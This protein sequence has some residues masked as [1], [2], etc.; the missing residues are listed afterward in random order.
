MFNLTKSELSSRTV[1]YIDIVNDQ[2]NPN[3]YNKEEDPAYF[4]SQVNKRG[5][6]S[7]TWIDELKAAK[8]KTVKY[9]CAYKLC[10]IEIAVWGCQSR[11]ERLVSDSVLRH[12][13]L[14]S[15]RQA[16]CW[17]D[18]YAE[19]TMDEVRRLE[20]ETQHYLNLKMRNDPNADNYLQSV[21]SKASKARSDIASVANSSGTIES[22]GSKKSDDKSSRKQSSSKSKSKSKSKSPK[23]SLLVGS[24]ELSKGIST[25]AELNENIAQSLANRN[26]KSSSTNHDISAAAKKSKEEAS[27][28][29]EDSF[30]S[31]VNTNE[32]SEYEDIISDGA[33][34]V[35]MPTTAA[36]ASKK[37]KKKSKL[38][39]SSFSSKSSKLAKTSLMYA[40]NTNNDS[41]DDENDEE[42]DDVSQN[43]N[44]DEFYDAICKILFYT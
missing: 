33:V 22:S 7:K 5:P 26:N 14:M 36:V 41:Y 38:R 23:S 1:D 12:M 16:W 10:R 44:F 29:G 24:S 32:T 4:V 42:P 15:H 11:V 40:N 28:S 31:Q 39:R 37:S 25:V 43:S 35:K 2:I 8:S 18:E 6:L 21:E 19:L 27:T 30:T 34:P 20:L 17:Q 3:E 9:M 13:I